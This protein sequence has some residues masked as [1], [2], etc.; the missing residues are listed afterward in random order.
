MEQVVQQRGHGWRAKKKIAGD[1]VGKRHGY[2]G[3]GQEGEPPT[4]Q[5]RS[6]PPKRKGEGRERPVSGAGNGPRMD[7]DPVGPRHRVASG[8]VG[9]KHGMM[10]KGDGT[11][12]AVWLRPHNS[13]RRMGRRGTRGIGRDG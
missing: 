2:R 7:E 12:K 5:A 1:Q 8:P 9:Y 3:R 11:E 6:T 4:G 13:P 10:G